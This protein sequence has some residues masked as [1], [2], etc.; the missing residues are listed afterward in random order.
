MGNTGKDNAITLRIEMPAG[1]VMDETITEALQAYGKQKAREIVKESM[2]AEITRICESRIKDL[3]GTWY[4][5]T[6]LGKKI[7]EAI[8]NG[9]KE[10][11]QS[12]GLDKNHMLAELKSQV[13]S[14]ACYTEERINKALMVQVR[15]VAESLG[16]TNE[17]KELVLKA[18]SHEVQLTYPMQIAQLVDQNQQQVL[19]DHI[20]ELQ[21]VVEQQTEQ[22]EKDME[23]IQELEGEIAEYK[24]GLRPDEQEKTRRREENDA[25][26]EKIVR[27]S[28]QPFEG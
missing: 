13:E 17:F 12:I 7:N 20:A 8:T 16:A 5:N 9:V 11:A 14:A 4:E 21:K 26:F 2:D 27:R 24:T 10:V 6:K 23:H 18:V 15:N 1:A 3:K 28:E 25:A 19:R 22:I